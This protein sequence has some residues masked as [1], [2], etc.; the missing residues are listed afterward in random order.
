[1]AESVLAYDVVSLILPSHL[2]SQD[3]KDDEEGT[4]DDHDVADGLQ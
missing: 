4:A 2:N 1:M 3:S